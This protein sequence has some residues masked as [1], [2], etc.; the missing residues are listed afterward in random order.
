MNS[1]CLEVKELLKTGESNDLSDSQREKM[2][3]HLLFCPDCMC[4]MLQTSVENG[5]AALGRKRV[6]NNPALK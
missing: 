2:N 4:L 1:E 5:S 6:G 3:G